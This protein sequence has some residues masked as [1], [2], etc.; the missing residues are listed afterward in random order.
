MLKMNEKL[1]PLGNNVE[2]I[3]SEC[4]HFST[5]T[6]LLSDFAS[7]KESD[8]VV[9][10]GTGCGTMPLLWCREKSYKELVALD[11]QEDAEEIHCNVYVQSEAEQKKAALHYADATNNGFLN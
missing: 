6:I 8:C 5:D 4:Y 11:I 2:I 9:E 7:P 10:L 3:V 1:E